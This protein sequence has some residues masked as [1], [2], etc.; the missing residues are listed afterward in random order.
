MEFHLGARY[1]G[2]LLRVTTRL[3]VGEMAK[4][5][6]IEVWAKVDTRDHSM[7]CREDLEQVPSR[8]LMHAN[9]FER[10]ARGKEKRA[11]PPTH[12]C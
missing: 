6:W 10:L 5:N 9:A 12:A 2:R 1:F 3:E 8:R 4:T 7:I 11:I